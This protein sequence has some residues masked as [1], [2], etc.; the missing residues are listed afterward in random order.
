MSFIKKARFKTAIIVA[1]MLTLIAAPLAQAAGISLNVDGRAVQSTVKPIVHNGTMLVSVNDIVSAFGAKYQWTAATRSLS[2]TR[3]DTTVK[4]V[5]DAPTATVLL[6]PESKKVTLDHPA[7]SI[8]NRVM[9]PLRFMASLYGAKVKWNQ[10]LQTVLITLADKGVPGDKGDTGATGPKGDKGDTGASGSTGAT[11]AAGSTGAAGPAGPAGAVEPAGATGAAGAAGPAGPAGA[12]GPEG[13]AGAVGPAG[14]A[15]AI[16]PAGPT[17]AVGPEGPAGAIGPEGPA[18][19]AGPAGP[20]G[21]V[22][23]EGPAGAIGPAGPTGAAGPAGPAGPT[24]ATGPQGP[25]G[26]AGTNYADEG[27]SAK[28]SNLTAA[29]STSIYGWDAASPYYAGLSFNAVTGTYTAPSTGKYTIK[30]TIPYKTTSAISVSLGAGVDPYFAVKRNATDLISA[31]LPIFNVNVAL[32]L[33]LRTI[34]G[35]STVTLDGDAILNAGDILTLDYVAD[36]LTIPLDLG[37]GGVGIVWSVHK[38]AD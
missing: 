11:G 17:G 26:P 32:V 10:E 24:G 20:T 6:G 21:A 5:L 19:A 4:F 22:G 9:V 18:G 31:P 33:T 15:G 27:F 13:P 3:E 29:T 34:L 2:V 12:V 30:A 37:A 25:A 1:I 14:P 23:P 16:G 38:I 7:Q 8:N 28:L 36:G 35:S